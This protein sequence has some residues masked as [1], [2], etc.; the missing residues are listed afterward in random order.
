MQSRIRSFLKRHSL[1]VIRLGHVVSPEFCEVTVFVGVVGLL[2]GSGT[3]PMRLVFDGDFHSLVFGRSSTKVP[4]PTTETFTTA[5]TTAGTSTEPPT[6]PTASSGA[7]HISLVACSIISC[8]LTQT[9][10]AHGTSAFGT[11]FVSSYHDA[12]SFCCDSVSCNN[13]HDQTRRRDL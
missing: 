1:L 7:C 13:G 4:V 2:G 8:T 9:T 11:S 10:S 3:S 6:K 5:I 12:I